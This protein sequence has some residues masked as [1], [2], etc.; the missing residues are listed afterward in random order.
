[1]RRANSCSTGNGFVVLVGSVA[2]A[3]AVALLPAV[4]SASPPANPQ[5]TGV[6]VDPVIVAACTAFNATATFRNKREI[7]TTPRTALFRIFPAAGGSGRSLATAPIPR[8]RPK[9]RVSVPA[10][11]KLSPEKVAGDYDVIACRTPRKNPKRCSPK[12]AS[13]PITVVSS[14]LLE[15]EP[16]EHDFGIAATGTSSA[17]ETLTVTNAGEVATGALAVG[18]LG[19][20]TH[21]ATSADGCTG[22]ALA[23][24]AT[25]SLDVA[26]A[27]T[28]VGAKDA[29]V[30][31]SG[32]PGGSAVTALTGTGAAPAA[33]EITPA[34]RDF[35]A[36]A[37]GTTSATQTFT[38]TNTGGVD[39]GGVTTGVTGDTSQ[40]ST[41]ASTCSSQ[42]LA[43]GGTC[44]VDFAFAPTTTGTKNVTLEATGAPGGTATSE[45]TG[46]AITPANLTIV[47]TSHAF[48][49]T[50]RGGA[51]AP[52]TF[53]VTN[54]GEAESSA[55]GT[56]LTG[57]NIGEFEISN[58]D[59]DGET[60]AGGDSCTV[61]TSFKPT[62][63]GSKSASLVA[64]AMVG[65]TASATLD[66]TGVDPANLTITPTPHDFGNQAVGTSSTAQTFT[67]ENTGGVNS[68]T[69]SA[70]SIGPPNGSQFDA[71]GGSNQCTGQV[72]SPGETCTYGLQFSPG[73]TGA[74]SSTL[75]FSASPGGTASATVSGTGVDPASLTISPSPHNFGGVATGSSS[76]AQTFTVEN[77]GGADSGALGA[78]SI[79]PPDGGQFSPVGGSNLCTGEVLSPGETCTYQVQFSPG[80]TGAKSTTLSFNASPG[81]TASAALSGTGLTPANLVITPSS[82]NF[83]NVLG[84]TQPT[85]TFTVTNTGQATA[86]T[87]GSPS[88][89]TAGGA[90]A[91]VGSSCSGQTLAAGQSCPMT[92][93]YTPNGTGTSNDSLSL[94]ASP[95]GSVSA[96]YQ[97]KGA[98]TAANLQIAIVD[99]DGTPPP[100]SSYGSSASDSAGAG[101]DFTQ[102]WIR[103]TG[104]ADAL[105]SNNPV[106]LTNTGNGRVSFPMSP[107]TNCPIETETGGDETHMTWTNI[108]IAGGT[109]CSITW[110]VNLIS[111][112]QPA[113]WSSS[114]TLNANPGGSIT[115]TY[116]FNG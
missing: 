93:R 2:T 61:D 115:G 97:G 62:T 108:R 80:S 65:G 84:G 34:T 41:G 110:F 114:F 60:L 42:T 26:F 56:L 35:G 19:A 33:L 59:C 6:S 111:I 25:C 18:L 32:A 69:L 9:A 78:A 5:V 67:I 28:T 52:Q 16:A 99:G 12:R 38:V 37:T 77:T 21:F 27:P 49:D 30:T 107:G 73:S 3:I 71:V 7:S 11:L 94:S 95:G 81:G 51:S 55:I 92:I 106:P 63:N 48:P 90:F 89:G 103:N 13:T 91:L 20:E 68:G 22:E 29:S 57:A 87:I 50:A 54:T 36:H 100:S 75:S 31:V 74:K 58:D 72:L 39:S 98:G 76:A 116:F 104:Q 85:F 101:N 44:T 66:G 64:T 45:L 88:V 24:G 10:T 70:A 83:G 82:Y 86:G 8:L 112:Q 96:T 105:I 79:G 14:Q 4:A 109:T 1:M 53:T 46:S 17:A 102:I 113:I 23:P 15:I 40:F 47:P 43:P